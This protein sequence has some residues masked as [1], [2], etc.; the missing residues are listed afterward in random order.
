VRQI[1][2]LPLPVR[3]SPG[4]LVN[5]VLGPYMQNAFR[6]LD[7][8][9][10]PE[11][12]DAAMEASACRWGRS[13]SPTPSGWISASPPGKNWRRRRRGA[14]GAARQGR[15]EA[16]RQEDRPG[17]LPLGERQ[18]GKGRARPG[19]ARGYEVADRPYLARLKLC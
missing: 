17:N 18:A 19:H 8:G 11:T 1:D 14:E 2:K 5:R 9:M 4:F 13:S 3:D 12:I 7:A 15:G 6:E 16:A 10:K